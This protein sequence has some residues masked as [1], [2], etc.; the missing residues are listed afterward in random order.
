MDKNLFSSFSCFSLIFMNNG[1]RH[2]SLIVIEF[3]DLFRS[4][5][6]AIATYHD[7]VGTEINLVMQF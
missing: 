6:Q 3:T 4:I 7:M 5:I 2:F 1:M